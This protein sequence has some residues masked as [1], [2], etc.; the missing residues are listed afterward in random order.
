MGK[1]SVPEEIR[2]LKPKGTSVKP[3]KGNYYVYTH[4]QVKD[5]ETGKWKTATGKLIGRIIP[6]IGF[7]SN[8]EGVKREVVT[9]FDYGE[10]LLACSHAKDDYNLLKEFFNPDEAMMLI[11]LAIIFSVKGYVGLKDA[12]DIYERSLIARDYP[13]LRFSYRRISTLL[14]LIGRTEMAKDFQKRCF[15]NADEVAIDGHAIPGKSK[16]NDLV[17]AGF[18]TKSI[19]SE[20]MNL[21][22]AL[23]VDTGEPVSTRVFPGYSLD[24]CVFVDFVSTLGSVRNKLI[25]VD[26]GFFS[27]E[28][29]DYIEENGGSYIVPVSENRKEYK[30]FSKSTRGRNA[31]FI[32]HRNGKNDV[33]EY[34]EYEGDGGRFIYF[35]NTTEAERLSYIYLDN[36]EKGEKGYS[37]EEYERQ[38]KKYGVILL[39]TN[40]KEKGAGEIY[41]HY[42]NRW[43]I[44]TYYDRLKNGIDFE[45]LNIDDWALAQGVAFVMLLAGRIDSRILKDAKKLKMTR[46]ELVSF[47][48]FL[49]L[50]DNGKNVSIHNRKKRHTEVAELL[51]LSFDTSLKCLG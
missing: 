51:G 9:C 26:M 7:C 30:E 4:S 49:K 15:G 10:Y 46:K 36:L 22:V 32:Y 45:A 39:E 5:P 38:R 1:Y 31:S 42:K 27:R 23:D 35:K 41:C 12:E 2:R 37:M 40:L 43:S 20:Y 50:T 21:M 34:R 29:M 11:S 25:L 18:K 24:K 28:N 44:E 48:K 47:M 33:V 13:A 8:D 17:S 19:K 14:E 3:I 6:G 16:E